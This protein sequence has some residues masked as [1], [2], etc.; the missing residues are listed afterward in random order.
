MVQDENPPH[1]AQH[2]LRICRRHVDCFVYLVHCNLRDSFAPDVSKSKSIFLHQPSVLCPP[3]HENHAYVAK[4]MAWVLLKHG[5][6]PLDV[7]AGGSLD[8]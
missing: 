1:L 8:K 3:L 2:P 6:P 5:R 4:S 7:A